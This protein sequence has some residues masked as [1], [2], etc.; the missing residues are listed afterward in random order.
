MPIME[1]FPGRAALQQRVLPE[2]RAPLFDRLAAACEGG[3]SVFAGQP[4]P[5]ESIKTSSRLGQ[6]R[7][8]PAANRHFLDPSHP[9]YLCW[10]PGIL[11]WLEEWDPEVLIAEANPRYPSTRQAIHWMQSRSRPVIGWGLGAPVIRGPLKRLR[12]GG[13]VRF[14]KAFDALV[15]YSQRGAAEYA[16]LGYPAGRIYVAA[17]AVAPRPQNLP[18]DR[19]LT[20]QGAP[21]ILFVGRLQ[22]RK[23]IDLLLHACAALPRASQ[24]YLTLVGDGPDRARLEK[25]AQAVFPAAEFPGARHGQELETFFHQADLFVLPGTGGLAVQQAMA[26]ALPVIV[27]QGDGTQEDLVRPGN[28][29]LLPPGDRAALTAALSHAFESPA[30]LRQMGTESYRIVREEINLE[31]MVE[32]FVNA[33]KEAQ[34]SRSA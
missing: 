31:K 33:L 25:L 29:W 6:A 15:A 22:A 11:D 5:A 8:Y 18:P 3:L 14:L 27:A 30:R 20:F 7:L 19:P 34:A 10:Q 26:Y 13:R 12:A 4:R 28:G 1:P 24:P 9:L 21:R 23:G 32:V 16:A 17:N 2:Y